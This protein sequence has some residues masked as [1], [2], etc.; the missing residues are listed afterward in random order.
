[1]SI[2]RRFPWDRRDDTRIIDSGGR[3]G[4]RRH[5]TTSRL[6]F[7]RIVWNLTL[8]MKLDAGNHFLDPLAHAG[9]VVVRHRRVLPVV[10]WHFGLFGFVAPKR[11]LTAK[12]NSDGT[13]T[14][15]FGGCQRE[16]TNCLPIMA[17]WN[18][19]VRLCRPRAEIRNGTWKFPEPQPVN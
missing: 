11:S 6:A 17:G 7:L 19:T 10:H 5:S 14:I 13:V 2:R 4:S 18:Y 3:N 15:L 8:V 12:P 16:T 1:M 9:I